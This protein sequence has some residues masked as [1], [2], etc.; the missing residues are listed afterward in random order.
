[1]P[2]KVSLACNRNT[3][4]CSLPYRK[5]DPPEGVSLKGASFG[6]GN[7]DPHGTWKHDSNLPLL[8]QFKHLGVTTRH[9]KAKDQQNPSGFG[10]MAASGA[11]RKLNFLDDFGIKLQGISCMESSSPPIL[12]PVCKPFSEMDALSCVVRTTCLCNHNH[13]LLH[14]VSTWWLTQRLH[15]S[16]ARLHRGHGHL[17]I[18]AEAESQ[19]CAEP[20]VKSDG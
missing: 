1:M 13:I 12:P 20:F 5:R 2:S 14:R 6:S 17:R 18:Q 7:C 19:G 3:L 8:D 4:P 9:P 16:E 11:H 15:K 10:E